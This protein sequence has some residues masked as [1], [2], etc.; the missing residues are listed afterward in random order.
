[1]PNELDPC[2]GYIMWRTLDK[3]SMP[4]VAWYV[5]SNESYMNRVIN[6]VLPTAVTLDILCQ[7]LIDQSACSRGMKRG[8]AYRSVRLGIPAYIYPL[9]M[10]F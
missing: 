7:P 5:L 1:M 2:A 6:D 10:Q 4:I 8:D 3:K 9:A